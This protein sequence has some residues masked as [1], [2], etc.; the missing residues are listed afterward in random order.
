[1]YSMQLELGTG[2]SQVWHR[3]IRVLGMFPALITSKSLSIFSLG[4]TERQEINADGN[5]NR[6]IN[7]C[8]VLIHI[9]EEGKTDHEVA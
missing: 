4:G 7:F 3:I 5:S 1:M 6:W 8:G 2:D 9:K